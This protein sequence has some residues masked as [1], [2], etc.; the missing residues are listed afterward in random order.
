VADHPLDNPVWNSLTTHHAGFAIGDSLVRRYDPE[1]GPLTGFADATAAEPGALVALVRKTGRAAIPSL[2]PLS[3]PTELVVERAA[4]LDQMV[5]DRLAPPIEACPPMQ[6]LDDAAA[7]EMLALATLTEPGPFG[8]R[9]HALGGFRGVFID[10]QLAA[11]A[12]ERMRVPGFG[13]VSAVCTHPGFRG[14]G[15]AAALTLATAHGIAARGDV[16]FLHSYSDNAGAIAL[17]ERLGF[18]LRRRFHLAIVSHRDGADA[19]SG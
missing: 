16:P 9:T 11:M 5:A 8:P 7:D 1:I 3:L 18:R 4:T 2:A 15:L 17:Y 12:G 6:P 10:G 19:A 14:R 13:E